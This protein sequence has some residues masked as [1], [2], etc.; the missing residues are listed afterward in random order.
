MP[1]LGDSNRP[2]DA[3]IAAALTR[4]TSST[5][6]RDSPQIVAFLRYVVERTL[7]G[8]D[9]QIKGYT[10]AVEALGRDSSFDPNTQ[11]IVR[12][13]AARLR[14]EL[15]RYYADGGRHDPVRIAL[16]RGRYVPV[17]L[18]QEP[19]PAPPSAP[20]PPSGD[21]PELSTAASS[22]GRRL[23]ARLS[24]VGLVLL[25]IVGY[26]LLDVL[27]IDAW[28]MQRLTAATGEL[29]VGAIERRRDGPR[30][31][32]EPIAT[33]GRPQAGA[34]D[35]TRVHAAL[36]NAL[37]RFEDI[38]V[39]TAAPNLLEAGNA[40]GDM[41]G[42]DYVLAPTLVRAAN[43][44]ALLSVR[45]I[46]M[47]DR[48]VVWQD[49]FAADQ[50]AGAGDVTP[51]HLI[52]H[53][54]SALL[55]PF[56]IIAAAERR[57]PGDGAPSPSH[58]LLDAT[59]VA[60]YFDADRREHTRACLEKAIVDDPTFAYGHV[61]L[62]RLYL[63]DYTLSFGASD[64]LTRALVLARRAVEL[65]PA[66]ARAHY[67]LM[68]IQVARGFPDRGLDLGEKALALNPYDLRVLM[69]VGAQLVAMGYIDRGLP[70]LQQARRST[71]SNPLPLAW[72]LFLAAYLQDD[73]AT[74]AISADQMPG[75]LDFNL[76][77]RALL[78]A[79][80][81][82]AAGARAALATLQARRPT[83]ID[84]ARDRLS[85]VIA[86]RD[87]VERLA[88]DLDRIAGRAVN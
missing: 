21:G 39:V 77:A 2:S 71:T 47:P 6:F 1:D 5:R 4:V 42:L 69:Q 28:N 62:A 65:A 88:G 54:T 82:D 85:R 45:L 33:I 27:V 40:G 32:I 31:A 48:T 66:S 81:G 22:T 10:I 84:E 35:A 18:P 29:T 25:G 36:T 11:S 14:Q 16:P 57:K 76:V 15:A 44:Q 80:M 26:G 52:L 70:L 73:L 87:I 3:E 38:T 55:Q 20:E 8:K 64:N 7:A 60:R 49:D 56:G 19:L 34:L 86:S 61:L 58:C 9:D 79:R 46:A 83:W 53:I 68:Q 17:F 41:P 72:S 30:I 23:P 67:T 51:P 50:A 43:G 13:E 75:D 74:A 37:S 59:Q 24:S 78:A 63:R 12:T